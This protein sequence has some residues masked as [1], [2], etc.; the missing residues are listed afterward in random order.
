MTFPGWGA[1]NSLTKTGYVFTG[2][3]TST[4]TCS[5]DRTITA[6]WAQCTCADGSHS[7]C[8]NTA[9]VS[10]N[11]CSYNFTCDTH[12]NYGGASGGPATATAGD[13]NVTAGSCALTTH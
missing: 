1:D 11:T 6:Q 10:N 4:F 9:S 12:Y 2:W 3:D 13:P 5:A 8:G 7:T